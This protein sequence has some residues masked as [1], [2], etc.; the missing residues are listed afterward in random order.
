VVWGSV[1]LHGIQLRNQS[2]GTCREHGALAFSQVPF[3]CTEWTQLLTLRTPAGMAPQLSIW[4][5]A[6]ALALLSAAQVSPTDPVM[7]SPSH[8][9]AAAVA[10]SVGCGFSD[11]INLLSSTN[12]VGVH[13]PATAQALPVESVEGTEVYSC[14]GGVC[15]SRAKLSLARTLLSIS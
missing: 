1:S 11:S 7:C 14:I 5:L 9:V 15:F 8:F 10:G 13:A 4:T 3:P 12:G 2:M 6:V